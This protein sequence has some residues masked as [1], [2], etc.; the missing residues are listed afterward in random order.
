[1]KMMAPVE[2]A[3]IE[4]YT[5]SIL[6]IRKSKKSARLAPFPISWRRRE[7]GS[8]CPCMCVMTSFCPSLP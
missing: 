7:E 5:I 1:M 2:L 3:G 8:E 6:S 4:F